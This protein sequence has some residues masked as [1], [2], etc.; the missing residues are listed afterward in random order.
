M[1]NEEY[2]QAHDLFVAPDNTVR[3]GEDKQEEQTDGNP[4]ENNTES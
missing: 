3:P 1:T 4:T 2:P